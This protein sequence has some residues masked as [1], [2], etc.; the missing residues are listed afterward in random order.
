MS[1]WAMWDRVK[2]Y[3]LFNVYDFPFNVAVHFDFFRIYIFAICVF[4]D[5]VN[6]DFAF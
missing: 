4:A 6:S 3:S 2:K 5:V 1:A